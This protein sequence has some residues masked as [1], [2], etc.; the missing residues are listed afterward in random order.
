MQRTRGSLGDGQ[1]VL[2]KLQ[3]LWL[4]EN[5]LGDSGLGALLAACSGAVLTELTYVSLDKNHVNRR[6]IESLTKAIAAGALRIR[7]RI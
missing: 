5:E 4:H 1:P 3:Q 2:A 6:G 7:I